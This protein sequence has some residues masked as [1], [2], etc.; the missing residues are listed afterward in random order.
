M[1]KTV[2]RRAYMVWLLSTIAKFAI[3]LVM[4]LA[5]VLHV[6]SIIRLDVETLV[7]LGLVILLWSASYLQSYLQHSVKSVEFHG[8][9]VELK[10]EIAKIQKEATVA[11]MTLSEEHIRDYPSVGGGAT[12][13]LY[14]EVVKQDPKLGLAGVRLDIEQKLWELA[15][16][17]N[18]E[19][20]AYMPAIHLLDSLTQL[21]ALNAS[22]RNV[23]A[24]TI[25]VLDRAIRNNALTYTDAAHAMHLGRIVVGTLTSRI[26][27][28]MAK[29]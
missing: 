17:V 2:N 4:L 12:L 20:L 26:H 23:I 14:T 5:A 15:G 6:F 21:G 8:M 3:S 7:L 11:G 29:G 28:L 13:P 19:F 18:F 16:A 9:K 27:A 22:E 25:D 24:E 1:E 10:D